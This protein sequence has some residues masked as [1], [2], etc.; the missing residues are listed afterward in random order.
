MVSLTVLI[1]YFG[2]FSVMYEEILVISKEYLTKYKDYIFD[3]LKN[4][5]L[6]NFTTR[7]R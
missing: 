6:T 7:K 2:H 4:Y 1:Q 3:L 5:I